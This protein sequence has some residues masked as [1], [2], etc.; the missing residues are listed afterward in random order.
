MSDLLYLVA[1]LWAGLVLL[2]GL[3]CAALA[4]GWRDD[5]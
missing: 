3:Y 1:S 5:V 2:L 4:L